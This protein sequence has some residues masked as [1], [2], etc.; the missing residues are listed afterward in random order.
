MQDIPSE[1]LNM[2]IGHLRESAGSDMPFF[3]WQGTHSAFMEFYRQCLK[4]DTNAG[5]SLRRN[6]KE[7]EGQRSWSGLSEPAP[8]FIESG[9]SIDAAREFQT[10]TAKLHA[11][12]FAPGAVR[13]A[14]AGGAWIIPL[15]LTGAPMPARIRERTKLPPL[16]INLGITAMARTNWKDVTKSLAS[17]AHAAWQYLQA[18]GALTLTANYCWAFHSP[19]NGNRG[20][21]V[22]I[23]APL[24]S[25]AAFAS[26]CSLQTARAL[27]LS[28]AQSLSGVPNGHDSIPLAYWKKPGLHMVNGL[29]GEDA[30][31]LSALKIA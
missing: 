31:I 6:T 30:G 20:L 3:H 27:T 11:D 14:V 26:A 16:N 24:T 28:L 13:P 12:R 19:M 8:A 10:T 15:T 5:A 9:I 21:V 7:L 29:A 2:S 17:V 22:S 18:G 25:Q 23:K 1:T 4:D